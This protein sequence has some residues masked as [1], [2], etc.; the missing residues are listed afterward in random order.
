LAK[1]TASNAGQEASAP[2]QYQDWTP[3]DGDSLDE[4]EEAD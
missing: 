3:I 4:D 1:Y 2:A